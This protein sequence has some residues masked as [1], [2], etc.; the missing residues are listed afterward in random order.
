MSIDWRDMLPVSRVMCEGVLL[1]GG[2][3]VHPRPCAP[4]SKGS[5]GA[6]VADLNGEGV[7]RSTYVQPQHSTN[8]LVHL[9]RMVT[10]KLLEYYDSHFHFK[11]KPQHILLYRTN[12][13][14]CDH[15]TLAKEEVT[16]LRRATQAMKTW[17]N[18]TPTITYILCTHEHSKEVLREGHSDPMTA[19]TVIREDTSPMEF[20]LSSGLS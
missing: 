9:Q 1:L 14:E 19:G 17:T 12:V 8:S 13:P 18:Y 16:A 2:A 3:V 11:K 20:Y 4:N 5:M 6:L 7:Y 15:E 10:N